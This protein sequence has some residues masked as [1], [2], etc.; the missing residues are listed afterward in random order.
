MKCIFELLPSPW[1]PANKEFSSGFFTTRQNQVR[2]WVVFV[3]HDL[4]QSIHVTCLCLAIDDS[5]AVGLIVLK[6]PGQ[7]SGWRNKLGARLGRLIEEAHYRH[8]IGREKTHTLVTISG[9]E[10]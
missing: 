7:D 2:Q 4:G 9:K 5:V 1:R 8:L 10:K 3:S 6:A